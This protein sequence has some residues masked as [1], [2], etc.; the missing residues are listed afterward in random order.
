MKWRSLLDTLA[1]LAGLAL[2]VLVV[3]RFPFGELTGAAER[4]GPLVSISLV[5]SFTY[6]ICTAGSMRALL[7]GRVPFGELVWARFIAES[8]NAI[9]AS[10]GGEPFR[11]RYLT[12][13]VSADDA[14]AAVV[15]ERVIDLTTGYVVSGVCSAAATAARARF[16]A[17]R[18]RGRDDR[19][20]E[21]HQ[22]AGVVT[23]PGAPRCAAPP[24]AV[25]LERRQSTAA[26][27]ALVAAR[28]AVALGLAVPRVARSRYPLVVARRRLVMAAHRIL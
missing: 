1:L 28:A 16:I 12:R 15:R 2:F 13:W 8:Y 18:L 21:R 26:A 5:F 7:D 24:L 3:S 25:R 22:C 17:R 14:L 9:F 19:R 11:I 10:I 20:M 4:I 27:V 6:L 23:T